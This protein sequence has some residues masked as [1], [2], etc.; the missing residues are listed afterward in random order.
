MRRHE[1]SGAEA[2]ISFPDLSNSES[3]RRAWRQSAQPTYTWPWRSMPM[4]AEGVQAPRKRPPRASAVADSTGV[5]I[6]TPA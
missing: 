6:V 2:L 5:Q 3:A 4:P 1:H